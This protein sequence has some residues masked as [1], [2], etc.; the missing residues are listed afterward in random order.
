[1]IAADWDD[2]SDTTS[3]QACLPP[4]HAIE[5][6]Q[7]NHFAIISHSLGSRITLDGLQRIA[8]LFSK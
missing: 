1:M 8:A 7:K 2:L 4:Q 3:N 5:N 6:M